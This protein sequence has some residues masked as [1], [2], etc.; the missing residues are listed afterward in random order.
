MGGATRRTTNTVV[1]GKGGAIIDGLGDGV[2]EA[3]I[4]NGVDAPADNVGIG[5]DSESE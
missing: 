3:I 5:E 2:L 4:D 1:P